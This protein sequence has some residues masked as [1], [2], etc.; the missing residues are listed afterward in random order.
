MNMM[1]TQLENQDPLNP[2]SSDEL[3]TQDEPGDRADG[4]SSNLLQT[5]LERLGDA[6]AE[7][8]FCL[9]A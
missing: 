5:A 2:T 7:I 4:T 3:M 1:I 6:D 8:E 9:E